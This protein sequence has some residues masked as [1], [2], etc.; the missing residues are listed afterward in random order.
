ML[1]LIAAGL[2]WAATLCAQRPWWEGGPLRII[3]LTTS[4]SQI[5]SNDPAESAAR[6]ASL[7]F[8]SKS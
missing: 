1:R 2:L 7:G 6:K 3:D 5:D 8:T 4:L